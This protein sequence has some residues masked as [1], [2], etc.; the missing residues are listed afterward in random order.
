MSSSKL[1]TELRECNPI[2]AERGQ[3]YGLNIPLKVR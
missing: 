2:R 1:R 3:G